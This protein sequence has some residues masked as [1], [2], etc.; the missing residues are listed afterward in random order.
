MSWLKK[1]WLIIVILILATFFRLYRIDATMTFL[2]DEGRDLLIVHRMIDTGR[3]VLLGPQT[4]TGNMYLGP[5]YYYVITPSL[6]FSGMNPVGPSIFIALSGVFTTY[7]IY[8]YGKTWLSKTT[9]YLASFA[10][11][12]LPFAVSVTRSSW[13]PNLVPLITILL[14]MVYQQLMT[15]THSKAKL[16]ALY[17]LLIGVMVQ[18][19][20]MALIFCGVLSL[21]LLIKYRANLKTLLLGIVYSLLGA[22]LILSPFIVFE[23]RNNW[24]N[25]RAITRFIEAKEERNIR[26]DLPAWLWYDKVS[27]TTYRLTSR[28]F[29]GT[30]SQNLL[31]TIAVGSFLTISL[32][33]LLLSLKQ[34]N[35]PLANLII[36]EFVML[37]L[38]GIYQENIHLH[39][40]E[41]AIPLLALTVGGLVSLNY[42]KSIKFIY[43][44]LLT[45][46]LIYGATISFRQI[47]SGANHQ[48]KKARDVANYI[49]EKSASNPYN[50]VSTQG[51]Y[52]TPFQYFLAISDHPPSNKLESTIYDICEGSP[53][54]QDD[55][56]TTLLFLTGPSHPSLTNYLGHPELNSFEQ[57]RQMV[58]NEH[59]SVGVWVGEI[60]LK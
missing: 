17:G 9:G 13:N 47:S 48:I 33:G 45:L 44:S 60:M 5:L 50:V 24:V 36:L 43:V 18:L 30:E 4:S 42:H 41:F 55:E 37:G 8:V 19:H 31:G 29:V 49:L 39:Y 1:H 38:L 11:A 20:Y 23:L 54:P 56:T 58:S 32:L 15:I 6:Y 14:L 16:W 34:K 2:E 28:L 25:T 12:I 59:V 7:L 10:F 51:M 27:T 52:T 26:Y 3:P 22:I 57:P 46:S 40:I 53:C 21:S 35:T